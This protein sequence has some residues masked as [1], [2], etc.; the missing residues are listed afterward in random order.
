MRH[1]TDVVGLEQHEAKMLLS[2]VLE[3]ADQN[4]SSTSAFSDQV[5]DGLRKA[6]LGEYHGQ[7]VVVEDAPQLRREAYEGFRGQS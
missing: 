4:G 2:I 1:F 3:W 6:V 5:E 7:Y